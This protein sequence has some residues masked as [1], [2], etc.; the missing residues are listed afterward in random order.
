MSLVV[1]VSAVLVLTAAVY[2]YFKMRNAR[3]TMDDIIIS[4]LSV[5]DTK[6]DSE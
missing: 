5:K 4:T 3:R 6:E 2:S 1:L